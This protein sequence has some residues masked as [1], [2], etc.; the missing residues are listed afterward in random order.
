MENSMRN[1][2]LSTLSTL[3][4]LI[5]PLSLS[6]QNS[7]SLS[8][9]VDGAA[10]DQA[11]TSLN[12]APNQV[13]AIQIFGKDIQN[14]NGIAVRFEYDVSQVV[15]EG[16]D[17]GDVLPNAQA[18]P[19][20][21]TGYVE[22]G[23]ASLG[24]Q[25]T[26]NSGL[27][28]T[29]RFR[30]T[31]GFSG[32]EIRLVRAELSRIG[33]FETITPNIRIALQ[34]TP[35][36]ANFSLS[37]DVDSSAGDQAVT[38]ANVSTDEMIAIEIFGTDIQNANGVSIRFEYDAGQV[39]YDGFDVGDVLPNAQALPEQGTGYVEIGIA[40]LG[41]QATANSGLIGTIRFRTT[42]A[43]SSTVIRV[44]RAELGRG[45]R[46]ETIT[47]DVRVEL[48]L[49][50]LTPD[51]NGD[52]VV[53]FTDFLAF[54]GQFGARQGD[55]RY[56]VKYDLDSDGAIGFGD[57][58]IFGNSFGKEVPPSGGSGG[59]GIGSGGATPVTIPDVN[60]R[61]AIEDSLGKASGA[62]ITQEEMASLTRLEAPNSNIRDLTG[63]EY[64]T[65]LTVL[66][67]GHERVDGRWINS[68]EIANLS[69]LSGMI[70]LEYL[71][72]GSN[73]ISDV[74]ALSGLTSLTYL[75][76]YDNF[77]SDVSPLSKLTNLI[78]LSLHSNLISDIS[79]LSGLTNLTT[80]TLQYNSISDVSALSGLTNLTRLELRDNLISDVVALSGMTKL[81]LLRL[82]S[83]LILDVAA[84]SNLTNLT[85]LELSNNT[86][87][88]I[89]ALSNLTNLIYLYLGNNTIS[90]VSALSN[91][92]KLTYLW[93]SGNLI[94]DVTALSNLT[95]LTSLYL[96]NNSISDVTALSNLTNLTRQ[97]SLAN[98][99][100]S[101]VAPLSNL[102]N[103]DDLWLS[104]NLI[105]DVSPLSN[106]TN[107]IQLSL[108][109]NLISDISTL[110]G[111]TN[112]TTLTLQINL[113]SDVTALS[114][115]TNLTELLLW[116]NTI[117]DVS[118]LS[119]LTNLT[120]LRLSSNL[121]SNISSL[122]SL[123]NLTE[124][125]LFNNTISDV[126]AL[127]SLTNLTELWLSRNTI[128]DLSPLVANMG[129]GSGDEVDV[130]D[131]PLSA[132]S[133]NTHIP[134]LQARGVTVQFGA[135]K[136]AVV[137][138]QEPRMGSVLP[139]ERGYNSL[140]R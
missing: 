67:L 74:S 121:I 62:P 37:L 89:S 5:Y 103:L 3:A 19:E 80:L 68:N 58:L 78:Q 55:G 86:I 84:L 100:I 42:G 14:A 23:M 102:T 44:V 47:I 51:F 24:G 130:R 71:D 127:S 129:L 106:L 132:I 126:T 33:R 30:T 104:G 122:S 91:L 108:H 88:D 35:P 18:L 57:F 137:D 133:L 34:G 139:E 101:D 43:F 118:A 124:L 110:S 125:S 97:L 96:R 138:K 140:K 77:I 29:V 92:T 131:N 2:I 111:L 73:L 119:S 61:A 10:G 94:S 15:Y 25:A 53:N 52:G 28:G 70:R 8:V 83:N 134:A 36:P 39:T 40:S 90:D 12:T 99:L 49:Q 72:L 4:L 17:T 11:V 16:F 109:S 116:D 95:K 69:P 76:L 81:T 135:G 13:I 21:G 66:D 113:I 50:S 82:D 65:G 20:Q 128:S 115:L 48:K 105:S 54:G 64:A 75:Y 32:T 63:L 120:E 26:A 59:G 114:S 87:S 6:A 79:T 117:S 45:G 56:E 31:A 41:G 27:V 107:L 60:L 98:N 93:L 123:T 1:L 46:F 112:L 136:P 85:R 22:I 38:S 7:F 9:D